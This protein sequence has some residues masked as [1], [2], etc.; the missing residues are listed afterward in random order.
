MKE[1]ILKRAMFAM[2]LSK[3][4][5]NTGIMS[6]FDMEEMEDVDMSII[7]LA[8]YSRQRKNRMG[9]IEVLNI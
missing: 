8:F 4:A 7:K 3:E 9:P 6:G 5:K 2:P 1:E